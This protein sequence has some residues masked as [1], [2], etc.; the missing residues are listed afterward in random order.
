[1]AGTVRFQVTALVPGAV[2]APL[3][4]EQDVLLGD[5][6][7]PVLPGTLDAAD[8]AQLTA[9]ELSA[10][11][12]RLGELP[13]CSVP[14]AGFTAEGGFSPPA[15]FAW[16]AAAEEEIKERLSRLMEGPGADGPAR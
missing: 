5:G 9:F 7:T 14:A 11:G 3:L 1:M 6:P 2:R 12:R 15:E 10:A 4:L 13:L 8:L 16:G